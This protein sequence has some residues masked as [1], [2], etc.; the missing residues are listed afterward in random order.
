MTG[1]IELDGKGD[2]RRAVYFV[3]QVAAEDPGRWEENR[4]VKQVTVAPP[5]RK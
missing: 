3:S 4:V 1:E 2:R 5:P